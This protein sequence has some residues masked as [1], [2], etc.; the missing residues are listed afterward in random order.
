MMSNDT[1]L[2]FG[3]TLPFRQPCQLPDCQKPTNRVY[4]VNVDD[5][6]LSFCS[7]DHARLGLTRWEEKKK[8][9]I[10]PGSPKPIEAGEEMMGSN[11]EA[12]EEGE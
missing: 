10:K 6:N 8:L 11:L 7:N 4:R 9:G 3:I 12:L 5:Y 1:N 2:S